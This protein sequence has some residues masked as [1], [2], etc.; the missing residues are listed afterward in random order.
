MNTSRKPNPG[1]LPDELPAMGGVATIS[2]A[3]LISS[4]RW[5]MENH[6]TLARNHYFGAYDFC[7]WSNSL[8][9]ILLNRAKQIGLGK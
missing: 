1:I 8:D 6:R 2:S 3:S 7:S 4:W 5:G 9:C